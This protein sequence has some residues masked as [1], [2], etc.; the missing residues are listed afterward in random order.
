[1]NEWINS[2]T[3]NVSSKNDEIW[4]CLLILKIIIIVCV[5]EKAITVALH[6][7]T[8]KLQ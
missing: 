8:I 5:N 2:K 4:L 6:R 3:A 7:Y 1:M